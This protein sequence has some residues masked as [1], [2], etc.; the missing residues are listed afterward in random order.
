MSVTK[1]STDVLLQKH[2][3]NVDPENQTTINY[4]TDVICI[5]VFLLWLFT[6]ILSLLQNPVRITNH[7]WFS[8]L[9]LLH[10]VAALVLPLS[11]KIFAF[12]GALTPYLCRTCFLITGLKL[13][14]F[15]MSITGV[16]RSFQYAPLGCVMS[17]WLMRSWILI[18]IFLFLKCFLY[19]FIIN[20]YKLYNQWKQR[21]IHGSLE[22]VQ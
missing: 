7:I 4:T 10:F 20:M 9:S 18:F 19:I 12:R 2:L 22:R 17:I 11:F 5:Q 13:R 14:L 1:N 21:V 6:N 15:G 8:C 16:I 3:L